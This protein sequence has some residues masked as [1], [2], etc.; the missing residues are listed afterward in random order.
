MQAV[1]NPLFLL[2]SI[3]CPGSCPTRARAQL[4]FIGVE[5]GRDVIQELSEGEGAPG[6]LFRRAARWSLK[7]TSCSPG[8]SGIEG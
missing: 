7:T 8:V 3:S 4:E 5:D 1:F 2:F 6:F